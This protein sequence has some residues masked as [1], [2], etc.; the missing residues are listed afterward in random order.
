MAQTPVQIRAAAVE[1]GRRLFANKTADLNLD[2]LMA[3]VQSIDTLM[4]AG[5]NALPVAGTIKQGFV[6]NLPEPFQ[7][8]STAQE[9]ALAL[10]VWTLAEVGIL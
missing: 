5:R 1:L 7:S 8:N 6:A 2:D 3:A 10:V 9:K 4:D